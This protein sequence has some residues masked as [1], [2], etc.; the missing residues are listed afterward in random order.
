MLIEVTKY[1]R[2]NT[3]PDFDSDLVVEGVVLEILSLNTI[4]KIFQNSSILHLVTEAL[5]P[6][7]LLLI[8]YQSWRLYF[9]DCI[10]QII[11]VS[12]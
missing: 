6:L 8:R 7:L 11:F 9:G 1:N 12:Q 2:E 10:C 4:L 3:D 5:K